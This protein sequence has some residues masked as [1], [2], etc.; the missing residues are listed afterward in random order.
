[1]I[2]RVVILLAVCDL[3]AGVG[4]ICSSRLPMTAIALV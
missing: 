1:M 2:R 4:R 3:S